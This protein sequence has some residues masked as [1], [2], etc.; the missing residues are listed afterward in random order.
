MKGARIAKGSSLLQRKMFFLREDRVEEMSGS[1]GGW[2]ASRL[3]F[4]EITCATVRRVISVGVIAVCM[5]LCV[6]FVIMA[7]A[8]MADR[9][10]M[11]AM[12]VPVPLALVFLLVALFHM[13]LPPYQLVLNAP[14]QSMEMTLPGRTRKR[15]EILRRI[16]VAIEAHQRGHVDPTA[17]PPSVP[18]T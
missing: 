3:F 17:P 8:L 15:E 14:G 5:L 10:A 6:V 1:L 18:V 9:N 11:A 16:T 7:I 13:L 2:E 12:I 4:D